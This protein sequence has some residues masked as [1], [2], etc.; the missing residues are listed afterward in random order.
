MVGTITIHSGFLNIAISKNCEIQFFVRNHRTTGYCPFKTSK[1][2]AVCMKE[3]VRT[4][5]VKGDYSSF[6]KKT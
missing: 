2:W 6:L 3:P 5:D 4:H 1:N